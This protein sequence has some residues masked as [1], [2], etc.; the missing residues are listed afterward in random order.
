MVPAM[1][2]LIKARIG[3][4]RKLHIIYARLVSGPPVRNGL[5]ERPSSFYKE[6]QESLACGE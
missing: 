6:S 5:K 1:V 4:E 2:S 3:S